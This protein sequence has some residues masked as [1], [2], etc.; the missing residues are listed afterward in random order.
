MS[1]VAILYVPY[2]HFRT[3]LHNMN[4]FTS[5]AHVYMTSSIT[6]HVA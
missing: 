3:E 5:L 6:K 1:T 2:L 4:N